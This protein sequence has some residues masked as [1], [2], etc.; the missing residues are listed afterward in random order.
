MKN[1]TVTF[2]VVSAL[3]LVA[4]CGQEGESFEIADEAGT[5]ENA[6]MAVEEM[7]LDDGGSCEMPYGN[8]FGFPAGVYNDGASFRGYDKTK[9]QGNCYYVDYTCTDGKW[10][11]SNPKW[12]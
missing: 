6:I 10:A 4:G 2:F 1:L 7:G 8:Y 9:N 12:C 11:A 3:S 5:E